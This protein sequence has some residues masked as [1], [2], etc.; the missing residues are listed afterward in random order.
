TMVV[1]AAVRYHEQPP[2]TPVTISTDFAEIRIDPGDWADA[3]AAVEPGVS[4]NEARDE[5]WRELLDILAGRLGQA[6]P[7]AV[8]RRALQASAELRSA[9]NRAW[10]VLDPA[11]VVG[12]LWSVPSYLRRCA[13]R[14]GD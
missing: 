5:I 1:D 12:D 2:A 13:P 9:F 3:F 14:L 7:D 10:P 8:A 6:V 4:H 11:G